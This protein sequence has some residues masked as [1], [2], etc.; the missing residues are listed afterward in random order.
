MEVEQAGK[1]S[2]QLK[3]QTAATAPVQGTAE[4]I[5]EGSEQKGGESFF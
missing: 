5:N 3:P 1:L 4:N 2:D